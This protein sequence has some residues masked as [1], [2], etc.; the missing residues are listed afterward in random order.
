MTEK[1]KEP[2]ERYHQSDEVHNSIGNPNKSIDYALKKH[3]ETKRKD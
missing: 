2:K 1:K 3:V